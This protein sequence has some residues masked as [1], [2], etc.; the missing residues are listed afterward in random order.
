MR[1]RLSVLA[2]A[3]IS[4]FHSEDRP[5][6]GAWAAIQHELGIQSSVIDPDS[7]FGRDP[8]LLLGEVCELTDLC[9]LDWGSTR[10]G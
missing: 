1:L 8:F 2:N 4:R 3:Q 5:V 10:E 9:E 6:V 7:I